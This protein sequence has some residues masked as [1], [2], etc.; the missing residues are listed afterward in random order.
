MVN[1]LVVLCAATSQASVTVASVRPF[2]EKFTLIKEI[3]RNN[4]ENSPMYCRKIQ[5]TLEYEHYF[6]RD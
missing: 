4:K 5:Y 1:M 2:M 6:R 3:K